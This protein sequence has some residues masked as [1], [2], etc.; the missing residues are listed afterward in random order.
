MKA[1]INE[2]RGA[3]IAGVR[4]AIASRDAADVAA[5]CL[6]A[7]VTDGGTD[8][9]CDDV[10]GYGRTIVDAKMANPGWDYVMVV[11]PGGLEHAMARKAVL[12]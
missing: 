2:A 8:L 1:K 10:V 9:V 7:A 3:S 5:G 4:A 11:R 12:P 6:Y